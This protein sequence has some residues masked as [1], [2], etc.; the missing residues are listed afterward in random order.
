MP[1]DPSFSIQKT[2]K[3]RQIIEAAFKLFTENGFYATGV[4]LIMRQAKVSKRTMYVYFPTKNDLI[5]TVLEFY[6]TEYERNLH[7]L[8]VRDGLSS[9]E[10]ILA[11][12]EGAKS[13]FNN[14]QFHGCLAVNAMGEFAGKDTSIENACRTFKLLELNVFREL[15]QDLQV[16][17]PDDLAYKL[18][19][20]L[21]G[22]G[23]LA[24]V[25][26]EPCP[27]DTMQMVKDMIDRH[28]SQPNGSSV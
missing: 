11:I 23:A 14:P 19:V 18:L 15:T 6:R 24:Q 10:K 13:W 21:E 5:V 9:R 20:L 17:E 22:L 4:D 8:L 1:T 25:L 26:K 16:K 7:T 28:P 2:A 27:I 12:F 3:R